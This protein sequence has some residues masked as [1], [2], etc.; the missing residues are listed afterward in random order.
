MRHARPTGV[1]ECPD[2]HEQTPSQRVKW[3]LCS[4]DYKVPCLL[5]QVGNYCLVV[6]RSIGKG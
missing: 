5:G 2:D 6:C 1:W 3:R 4:Q